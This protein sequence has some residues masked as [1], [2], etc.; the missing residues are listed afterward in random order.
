MSSEKILFPTRSYPYRYSTPPGEEGAEADDAAAAIRNL[1]LEA[2]RVYRFVLGL[3][4]MPQPL[5]DEEVDALLRDPFA[6]LLLRRKTFPLTLR[7]LLSAL[8]AVNDKPEGLPQQKSF[9]VADGGQIR[10]TPETANVNRLLRIAIVRGRGSDVPLMISA[11]TALDSSEQFLQ[12]IAWDTDNA[13]YNFYERRGGTWLWAGNSQHALLPDTR[14]QG[15]FDSHVNGSMVMK[16]LRAPW[17]NWHS[18]NAHIRE[19]VLAPDDPL[20]NEPL[21]LNRVPAHELELGVVR[22]GIDRWNRAHLKKAKSPDQQQFSDVRHFLRQVL[23]TTTV[24]LVSSDQE[25]RQV[26]DDAPLGLPTTFFLNTEALLDHI[27]LEPQ[28]TPVSVTGRLYNESLR[29]YDFTLTDGTYSQKGDT[30]FAFLV[31]EPA[32]EDISVLALLLQQKVIS[33]RFAACLLM[34]DFQN[35]IF[36][37]SRRRLMAYVPETARLMSASAGGVRSDLEATF[38]AALEAKENLAPDSPEREFLANWQ[39]P[40]TDWKRTFEKRIEDYFAHLKQKAETEKGFDGWVRLAESRRRE[41]RRRPLAEFRLT[42]P[43]TN[44]PLDAPTLTMK[45]DGS[46]AAMA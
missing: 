35:P 17:N 15:P 21:F 23:E 2:G 31:P 5:P 32:F 18:M 43:T 34:I 1:K 8:D 3:D 39:L 14:G 44:I 28:I 7:N 41:F 45:E 38:V 25:S 33:P 12:L 22:P 9:L 11:S 16:E 20:R 29:R 40:E 26:T 42:I 36:S 10:W 24:N 27:G 19:D 46:V 13:V 30:F 6:R 4:S 37:T